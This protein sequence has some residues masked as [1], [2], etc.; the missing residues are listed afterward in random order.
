ML[1][2]IIDENKS[3]N[4]ENPKNKAFKKKDSSSLAACCIFIPMLFVVLVLLFAF[5]AVADRINTQPPCIP[6][7]KVIFIASNSETNRLSKLQI[8]KCRPSDIVIAVMSTDSRYD[9]YAKKAKSSWIDN[10]IKLGY[11]QGM[12]PIN[13]K[14]INI[15]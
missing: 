4:N 15:H 1:R 8:E 13:I 12:K 14:P 10:A 9:V 2:R 3:I 7:A 6:L 5:S 11:D